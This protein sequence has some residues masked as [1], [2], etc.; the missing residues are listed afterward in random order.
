MNLYFNFYILVSL[1]SYIVHINFDIYMLSVL[2]YAAKRNKLTKA[3]ILLHASAFIE[4]CLSAIIS[5]LLFDP[6]GKDYTFSS[7][8]LEKKN[9]LVHYQVV[10]FSIA[11]LDF[12]L[13]LFL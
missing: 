6:L 1:V 4:T 2:D 10:L 3:I 12:S 13:L 9:F 7:G 11:I 5:I 8:L